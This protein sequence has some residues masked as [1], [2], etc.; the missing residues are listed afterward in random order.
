MVIDT[1]AILAILLD[2]PEADAFG[3]LME[4]DPLQLVSCVTRVE[5]TF[6]IEGRKGEGGRLRLNRFLELVAAEV[7]AVTADQ[8]EIAC[9]A[10]RRFGRGRHPANL[11]P[12]DVFSLCTCK[13]HGRA[14]FVQRQR[15]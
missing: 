3:R 11:N 8:A 9:E 15:L 14:T 6:V 7:I 10:F 4:A 1:S 13:V 5:A 12:G 2:E